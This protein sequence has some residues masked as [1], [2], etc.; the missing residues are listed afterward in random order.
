MDFLLKKFSIVTCLFI[1]SLIFSEEWKISPS[2]TAQDDIQSAMILAQEGDT[3]SLAAGIYNLNHG[4]SLDVDNI[5]LKGEGHKK[6]ILNF[7]EQKTG[8]QGLLV[9]SNNI[10]LKDFAVENAKGDAIKSKG[11]K[12]IKFLN[13]RTEWTNGPDT[14]NGAYGLYPVESENVLID[15]CIAIGASDAGVY[16]GQSENIIVRNLSLIHI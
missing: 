6:T 15:G 10:T 4:L 8:A 9:T 5:T 14:K 2:A 11:S 7:S 16:V 13:L 12:N 3:I 1:S